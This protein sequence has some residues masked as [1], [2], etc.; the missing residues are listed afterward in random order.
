V[1]L[2]LL[3]VQPL[4]GGQIVLEGL[5]ACG[6]SAA[7]QI[8]SLFGLLMAGVVAVWAFQHQERIS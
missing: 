3:P 6:V 2:N 7:D 5:R 1:I 8:A 4:D